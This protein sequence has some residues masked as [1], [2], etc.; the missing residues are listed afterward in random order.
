[1]TGIGAPGNLL[2]TVGLFRLLMDRK[3]S[4]LMTIEYEEHEDDP[5][6]YL[7]QCVASVKNDIA[8]LHGP[9]LYYKNGA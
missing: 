5:M 6:T 8:T 2:D 1:L 9:A 7:Q 4:H 3:Y